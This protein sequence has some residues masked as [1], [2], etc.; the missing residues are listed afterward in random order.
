MLITWARKEGSGGISGLG[1]GAFSDN[2]HYDASKEPC[3]AISHITAL[4]LQERS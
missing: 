4:A 1:S 2:V 3:L